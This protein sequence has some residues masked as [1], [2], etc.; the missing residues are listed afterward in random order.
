MSKKYI[1][2]GGSP[3]TVRGDFYI[4]EHAYDSSAMSSVSGNSISIAG[5][6]SVYGKMEFSAGS[7]QFIRLNGTSLQT[8]TGNLST[9]ISKTVEFDNPAGFNF[10]QSYY[11]DSVRM[12]NGN[13]NSI[14]GAWLCVGYDA[15]NP[16]TLIRTGGIVT[17]QLERWFFDGVISDSLEYPVGSSTTLK[18]AKVRYTTPPTTQGRIGIRYVDGTD[19]SD[20]PI[21][22]NDGGFTVTRRSNAY[23]ELSSTLISGGL[24]SLSIDGNGQTGINNGSDLRMVWSNTGGITFSL[25]GTHVNGYADVAKRDNIG[26]PFSRFYQAGNSIVNPLP[27]E[28]NSFM[29][30]TIKNE[31]ILDW[32][33]SREINNSGFDVQRA[34]ITNTENDNSPEYV[35]VAFIPSKG[36]SS[37]EQSYKFNDKNLNS[38]KYLYRLKQVDFNGNFRYY[39]LNSEIIIATPQV[40][41]LNQ[42]YPNPFNPSTTITFEL[43]NDS[44]VTLEIFDLTGRKVS[45]LINGNISAGYK[46][47]EFNGS[48]LASGVYYYK[49]IA[50]SENTRNEKILKMLLVK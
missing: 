10:T 50:T 35:S 40:F 23:W 41:S 14:M 28:M 34:D 27:V 33:T 6:W 12:V 30:S 21:P 42:N 13:I 18:T 39:N 45:S 8:I 36:N 4:E 47:I 49:L 3:L 38:G 22:L 5:D 29:A 7:N 32:S 31:V 46:Q 48:N 9:F 43:S 17:G 25:P 19:G 24:I 1:R 2:T 16:G 20:L 26:F 37:T 44:Y 15:T 11:V